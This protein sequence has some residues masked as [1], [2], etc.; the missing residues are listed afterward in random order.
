MHIHMFNYK[1]KYSSHVQ[2]KSK[3]SGLTL[4]HEAKSGRLNLRADQM[5]VQLQKATQYYY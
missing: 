5:S 4:W 3:Q 1:S 2:K